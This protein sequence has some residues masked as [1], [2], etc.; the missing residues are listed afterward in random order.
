MEMYYERQPHQRRICMLIAIKVTQP[1]H[2]FV[3]YDTS[4]QSEW[5]PIPVSQ[6]T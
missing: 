5:T 1:S 6:A 4:N 3:V 2:S